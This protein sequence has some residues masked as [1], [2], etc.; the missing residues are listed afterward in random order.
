VERAA[1]DGSPVACEV[2]AAAAEGLAELA[3]TQ[4]A[5]L[6]ARGLVAGARVERLVLAQ[7]AARLLADPALAGCFRV[8][9]EK[10]LAADLRRL[11]DDAPC[12]GY[13]QGDRLVTDW[14]VAS[15]LRRAP[16]IGA[17]AMALEGCPL[18]HAEGDRSVS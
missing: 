7:H 2:L 18:P 16:A 5:A 8:P 12:A 6:H 3:L 11:Q 9:L 10:Q 15:R 14:L 4:I 1:A 13:I 17:A